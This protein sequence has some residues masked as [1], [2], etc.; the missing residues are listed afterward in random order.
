MHMNYYVN[1]FFP[2]KSLDCNYRRL[3]SV[4]SYGQFSN[5]VKANQPSAASAPLRGFRELL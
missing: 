1:S 2:L 5:W 3:P 4:A